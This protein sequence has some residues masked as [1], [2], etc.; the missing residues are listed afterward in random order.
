M[1]RRIILIFL[2]ALGFLRAGGEAL[3]EGP[4]NWRIRFLDAAVVAGER[5]RLG[6]VA[7]PAG[8]IPPGKWEELA[9]RE[10]WT[11][12][13]DNGKAMSMT[14]P[15][16]QEVVMRTMPD[17][18]PYCLFPGSM[19]LQRGGIVL[20]E[21][22][23][24]AQVVKELTPQL[25][26]LDGETSIRDVRVPSAIFLKH[27]GQQLLVEAPKKIAA[28]RLSIRLLVRELDGSITQKLTGSV[29][30]D[31]WK[32][33]PCATKP[34]N[35]DEVL[36]PSAVTFVRV[37][38]AQLRET[39]WDGRGGPWRMTRPVGM[40]Q[41]I[42]QTDV[43]GIPTVAKGSVVTL[44]YESRTMRL[45]VKAEVMADGVTGA[46]VPVRNVESKKEIYAVVRDPS[47]V[48]VSALQ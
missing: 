27:S 41:V 40:E 14:R 32:T 29:F 4:P 6:E 18:A 21:A 43:A 20:D 22:T 16:L 10:L 9:G 48:V 37:N 25:S 47:T 17:L 5:V 42:Y 24:H 44:L 23:I 45:A 19:L 38:L 33:V 35:R 39:P 26:G 15:R 7:V 1:S 2:L 3:A 31:C 12:P 28:G 13:P 8:E 36:E 30:V 46:A 34:L 11:S